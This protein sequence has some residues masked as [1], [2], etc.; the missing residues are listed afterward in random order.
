MFHNE[1]AEFFRRNNYADS[2]RQRV[3]ASAD[4]QEAAKQFDAAKAQ[5]I[6]V[7]MI[8]G[9][10]DSDRAARL[11]RLLEIPLEKKYYEG[12]KAIPE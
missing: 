9:N 7:A 8:E 5:A 6:A 4:Y 12:K 3:Q 2:D 10:E 1:M 11:K